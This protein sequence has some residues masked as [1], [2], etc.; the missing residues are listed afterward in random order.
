MIDKDSYGLK[1]ERNVQKP[2]KEK[3]NNSKNSDDISL[4][5]KYQ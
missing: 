1:N 4:N 3:E 2:H 5:D